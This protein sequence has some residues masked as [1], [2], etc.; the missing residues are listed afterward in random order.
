MNGANSDNFCVAVRVRPPTT[1]GTL[2]NIIDQNTIIFG[3][4]HVNSAFI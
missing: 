4:I 1:D 2:L 3:I